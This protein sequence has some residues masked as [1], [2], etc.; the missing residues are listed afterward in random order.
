M[1]ILRR[2][3][4]VFVMIAE[5][6]GLLLSLAGL[7]GLIMVRPG[8]T[9]SISTTIN[10]LTTSVDTSTKAMVITNQALGAT[11]DSVDALSEMLHT[12]AITVQDT[13]PVIIKLNIITGE[14]LP[15]TFTA[16]TSSLKAAQGAAT[17]LESAIKSFETFQTVLGST[18][19]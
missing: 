10:T 4:G 18:P 1:S 19:F 3:L 7:T 8:L 11:V 2:I 14:T 13:Q 9:A 17:S 12:T 5:I 16:A 6:I 15:A